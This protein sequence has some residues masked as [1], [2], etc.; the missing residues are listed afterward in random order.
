MRFVRA[1]HE[2]LTS[3]VPLNPALDRLSRGVGASYA[4]ALGASLRSDCSG[5]VERRTDSKLPAEAE[6]EAREQLGSSPSQA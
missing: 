6:K 3:G 5:A 2:D 4:V 1:D